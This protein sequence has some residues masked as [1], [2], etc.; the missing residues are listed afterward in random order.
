MAPRSYRRMLCPKCNGDMRPKD[1]NLAITGTRDSFGIGKGFRD[2][3]TGKVI[4]NF[5]T[6][7]REGYK[8][9]KD[10]PT[11]SSDIRQ[12][13]KRKVEKIEKYD[14]GKRVSI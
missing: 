11:L 3:K 4:D 7:E 12:Q 6:W 13:I 2:P 1:F 5:R 8:D 9:Y 10:D 14:G